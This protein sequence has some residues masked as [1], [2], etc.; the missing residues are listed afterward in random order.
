MICWGSELDQGQPHNHDDTPFVLIGGGGGK[1]NPGQLVM[2]PLNLAY[3]SGNTDPT[4]NRFHNDLLITLAQV[5]GVSMSTFGTPTGTP[6][7]YTGKTLTLCA[8]PL[9]QILKS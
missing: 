3:G 9:T 4:G 2:F 7:R 5:M 8:G 6:S 1:L